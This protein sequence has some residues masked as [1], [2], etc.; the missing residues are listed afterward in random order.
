[1]MMMKHGAVLIESAESVHPPL[2]HHRQG[3]PKD[4]AREKCLLAVKEVQGPT[5]TED[6]ALCYN[7]LGGLPGVYIKW[8]LEAS[9]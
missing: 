1:M 4:V 7:A 6:T 9:V 2:H 5:I 8:F 3:E